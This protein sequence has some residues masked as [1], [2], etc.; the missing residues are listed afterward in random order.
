MLIGSCVV[1]T[2][3][4]DYMF[5]GE[6]HSK[7]WGIVIGVAAS[8][9]TSFT[10]PQLW[11]VVFQNPARHSAQRVVRLVDSGRVHPVAVHPLLLSRVPPDKL[12]EYFD[13]TARK[14]K[15]IGSEDQAK[16]LLQEKWGFSPAQLGFWANNIGSSAIGKVTVKEPVKVVN[17]RLTGALAP[18]DDSNKMINISS[19]V[20]A[21]AQQRRE[22]F[23]WRCSSLAGHRSAVGDGS[24]RVPKQQ[25]IYL[26]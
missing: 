22:Y 25:L 18:L 23:A 19:A 9:F 7:Y 12:R 10:M 26:S 4:A 2:Q 3:F 1:F 24:W 11:A 5:S 13:W 6:D 15:D 21:N 20:P 14:L 8:V 16:K 17:G